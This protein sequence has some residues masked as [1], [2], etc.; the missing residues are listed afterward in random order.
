MFRQGENT[1]VRFVQFLQDV[2]CRA[3]LDDGR[4]ARVRLDDVDNVFAHVR[5]TVA[6]V[7]QHVFGIRGAIGG[8]GYSRDCLS[9][10]R[11][12]RHGWGSGWRSRGSLGSWG[13]CRRRFRRWLAPTYLVVWSGALRR[14]GRRFFT[15]LFFFF[16][17]PFIGPIPDDEGLCALLCDC[18]RGL[19]VLDVIA[20][21]VIVAKGRLTRSLQVVMKPLVAIEAAVCADRIVLG[22]WEVNQV[23]FDLP[24]QFTSCSEFFF[25]VARPARQQIA[26]VPWSK[27]TRKF[28]GLR[29][30]KKTDRKLNR[31]HT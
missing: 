18:P 24:C 1:Y 28:W 20:S 4:R 29:K 21:R 23:Q 6:Q 15:H 2:V 13:G 30:K 12:G 27:R 11:G 3:V 26:G 22:L 25:M 14:L 5:K 16:L 7:E 9:G 8:F 31:C 17:S 10:W 19:L